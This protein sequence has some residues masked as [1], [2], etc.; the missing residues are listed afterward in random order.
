[1][2]EALY[3]PVFPLPFPDKDLLNLLIKS[4][5]QLGAIVVYLGS[6]NE[7][8]GFVMGNLLLSSLNGN[9][10]EIIIRRHERNSSID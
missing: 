2:Q 5:A 3:L 7:R 8:I 1:M 6:K 4:K 9:E 10:K